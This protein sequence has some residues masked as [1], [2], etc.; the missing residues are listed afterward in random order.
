MKSSILGG[1]F[2]PSLS[3]IGILLFLHFAIRYA[4]KVLEF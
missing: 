4:E 3:Q 2:I 1:N